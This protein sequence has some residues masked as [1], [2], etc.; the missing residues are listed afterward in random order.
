MNKF[1]ELTLLTLIRTNGSSCLFSQGMDSKTRYKVTATLPCKST[2]PFASVRRQ[3][4][5]ADLWF[6][7]LKFESM[8][9]TN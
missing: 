7:D 8:V 9:N 2:I 6:G 1:I 5:M 4:T 3:K